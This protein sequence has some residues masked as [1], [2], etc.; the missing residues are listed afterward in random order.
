[1]RFFEKISGGG[2]WKTRG[3]ISL[4]GICALIGAECGKVLDMEV[5]SSY[6]KGCDSYKG[7]KWCGHREGRELELNETEGGDQHGAGIGHG[8]MSGILGEDSNKMLIT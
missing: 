4:I 5:M 7:P 2:T 1:M 6:C 3:Q 8:K